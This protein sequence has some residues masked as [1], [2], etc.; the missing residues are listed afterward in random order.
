M[1]LIV[2]GVPIGPDAGERLSILGT[3]EKLTALLAVP[4]MVTITD[5]LVACAGTGTT[6]LVGLQVVAVACAPLKV[7][8]P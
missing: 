1:P 7:T 2:T 5:P 6:M 4:L 8:E 3:V